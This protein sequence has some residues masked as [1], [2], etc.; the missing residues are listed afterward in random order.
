MAATSPWV[1]EPVTEAS[2]QNSCST[3]QQRRTDKKLQQSVCGACFARAD[4]LHLK[5]N[6]ANEEICKYLHLTK[7][8]YDSAGEEL[9]LVEV[10]FCV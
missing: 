8:N 1:E 2:G 7:Q 10:T 6:Q 4:G 5:I 9:V 3:F